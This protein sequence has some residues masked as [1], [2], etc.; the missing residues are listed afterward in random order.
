ML[1]NRT[2]CLGLAPRR[3][4][5]WGH[6]L[7]FSPLLH[8]WGVELFLKVGLCLLQATVNGSIIYP[9]WILLIIVC[10]SE[11]NPHA[12]LWHRVYISGALRVSRPV[13][14]PARD[15][16]CRNPSFSGWVICS[17]ILLYGYGH[18]RPHSRG[19]PLSELS[20]TWEVP[21]EGWGGLGKIIGKH[22]YISLNVWNSHK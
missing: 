10:I 20:W 17:V 12:A 18:R 2:L 16:A 5:A 8:S 21:K 9:C 22:G 1:L 13:C 3:A 15:P 7:I 19:H 11:D 4:H 6:Q 14:L